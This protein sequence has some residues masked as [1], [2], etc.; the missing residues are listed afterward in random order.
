MKPFVAKDL[1]HH[2][3]IGSLEGSAAHDYLA[4]KVRRAMRAKDGS[5]LHMMVGIHPRARAAGSLVDLAQFPK[6]TPERMEELLKE[7]CAPHRWEHYVK[8]HDLDFAYEIPG[9]ARFRVNYLRNA[10][11]MAAVFRQIPSKILSFE[12]L[13]LPEALKK[14]C[15]LRE[16][17]VL[18]TGPT[19]SGKSTTLAA[20]IH[21][22]HRHRR[23]P[24]RVRPHEQEVR[25]RPP[26]GP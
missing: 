17:L 16:G 14:L 12:D 25:H 5:D 20:M 3:V 21:P 9:L 11:G 4:F 19:G 15:N 18:V 8:H 13:K 1:F 6:V 2:R 26:R 24:H 23:G 22:P 7:I 10:W